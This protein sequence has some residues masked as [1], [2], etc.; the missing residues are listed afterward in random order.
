M[1]PASWRVDTAGQLTA[2][3][4]AQEAPST[5]SRGSDNNCSGAGGAL[6]CAAQ[7]RVN[8]MDNLEV[9]GVSVTL[10]GEGTVTISPPTLRALGDRLGGAEPR[11]IESGGEPI[12]VAVE[13][14][15]LAFKFSR[16]EA[17]VEKGYP[18]RGDL[19]RVAQSVEAFVSTA[20]S[21][22]E[23]A[24][25]RYGI[26]CVVPSDS[27]APAVLRKL[28]A[29][30]LPLPS[31]TVLGGW[32]TLLYSDQSARQWQ[33]TVEPRATDDTKVFLGGALLEEQSGLD[34]AYMTD[35]LEQL[36]IVSG[37]FLEGCME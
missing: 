37:Q 7:E 13:R 19:A 1:L 2:Q 11:V 33:F 15:H 12:G 30:E 28:F 34:V 9:L 14:E 36:W 16:T 24:S 25:V 17:L 32:G 3:A 10:Q 35:R 21:D 20:I 27:Q 26:A 31:W 29:A 4:P 22:F 8:G 5:E 6:Y 18:D 23:V